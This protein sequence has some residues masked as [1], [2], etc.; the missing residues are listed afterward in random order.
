MKKETVSL[1]WISRNFLEL[2]EKKNKKKQKTKQIIDQFGELGSTNNPNMGI[3]YLMLCSYSFYSCPISLAS[4]STDLSLLSWYLKK[5]FSLI[6]HASG[7]KDSTSVISKPTSSP[8]SQR[9]LNPRGL[10][11]LVEPRRA[12]NECRHVGHKTS[13]SIQEQ[14]QFLKKLDTCGG[15][16]LNDI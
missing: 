8:A 9:L 6:D 14:L 4:L 13:V 16:V 3:T 10:M 2:N 1:R 12:L 7:S 5:Y 15:Y 11:A